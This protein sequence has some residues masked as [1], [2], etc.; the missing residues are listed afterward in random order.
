MNARMNAAMLK[1]TR[2]THAGR[3]LEA[4]EIIQRMLRDVQDGGQR[5]D[6]ATDTAATIDGEFRVVDAEC[7]RVIASPPEPELCPPPGSNRTNRNACNPG[8][9]HE[10]RRG[11]M[12][13]LS[14]TLSAPAPAALPDG[15]QFI[16]GSYSNAA[17]TRSYKLYIPSRYHGQPL[18]L[19][20]M[21]HGCTQDPDDFATGTR[22]NEL[23]EKQPCFVVYPV[24]PPSANA[25]KCW[26]WFRAADQQRGAGEP[27]I[28][29]GITRLVQDTYV[30]DPRR[31]Y[32]AGLSAGGA[33]A[34]TMAIAYPDV[35]AAVGIHSGLP[36]GAARDLPSALA[37]MRRARKSP[38]PL[39]AH[40]A[41][42][43]PFP[44][45]VFHGDRDATVHPGNGEHVIAQCAGPA[46]PGAQTD[47]L[48]K[49]QQG[50]VPNGR[51]YSRT[52]YYE[53]HGQPIAE[54][55]LIHGAGHA[56]SGGSPRGS[57][58]DPKGPDAT[59]QMLRFFLEH[60]RAERSV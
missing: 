25:S 42:A 53:P 35:Y 18:P 50:Q 1:A 23:A 39:E 58:T 7:P 19:V 9:R 8:A 43:Q 32:V 6:S 3:L 60:P 30:V 51:T 55:W 36:H 40:V 16:T 14:D 4:T 54:H 41:D 12:G 21:L 15:A 26:N 10:R 34:A 24:Q 5:H 44:A 37:M 20:V 33:M 29:A 45:I 38:L 49:V 48:V 22:M 46:A 27:S 13:P 47:R 11:F 52:I 31:I 17:G 28:I 56:W 2:L 57:H 59:Q